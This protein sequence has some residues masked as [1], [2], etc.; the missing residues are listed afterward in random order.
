MV[1]LSYR[2]AGHQAPRLYQVGGPSGGVDGAE[3]APSGQLPVAHWKWRVSRPWRTNQWIMFAT[4]NSGS[5]LPMSRASGA[6]S[7]LV[8]SMRILVGPG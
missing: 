3:T 5:G 4:V 1:S 2:G 6:P 7:A 8:V